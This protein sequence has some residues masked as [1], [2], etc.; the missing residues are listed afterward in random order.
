VMALMVRRKW[1]IIVPFVGLSA[2][3]A[4]LT[5]M[6][7]KMYVSQS[8][9]LIQPRDVPSDFVKDLVSG[10]S[11]QRLSVIA[12]KVLNRDQLVKI[13]NTTALADRSEFIR[14]NMDD[15]VA[16]LFKQINLKFDQQIG[17]G[18]LPVTSF[19]ITY[20]NGDKYIAKDIAETVTKLFLDQDREN[21]QESVN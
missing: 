9:I 21:R 11:E 15:R 12:T 8:R 4:L 10:T 13:L 2:A 6:L 1:W 5:Y 18:Q 14:L 3:V 16:K 19:Q 17:N 20:Q 7:P